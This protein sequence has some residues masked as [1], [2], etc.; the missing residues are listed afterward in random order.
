MRIFATVLTLAV[1]FYSAANGVTL[2][3]IATFNGMGAPK[4][5]EVSP[6]GTWVTVMNLEGMDVTII[7]PKTLSIIKVVNFAPYKTSAQGHNYA[8]HQPIS[9]FAEKPVEC[10][11][12]PDGQYAWVSFHNGACVVRIDKNELDPPDGVDVQKAK[13][14]DKV[15][16]KSYVKT[17]AK[18]KVLSTPKVVQVTPDGKYVLVANW[19]GQSISVIDTASMKKIKDIKTGDNVIPRGI[20][21]T[22]DS[23]TAYVANMKGGSIAIIDLVKLEK[24]KN[25]YITSNPR[26]IVLSPDN[27]FLYITDNSGGKVIKYDLE[28]GKTVKSQH[29]G[30]QARTVAITP[31][32]KYLIAAAHGS[33]ELVVLSSDDLKILTKVGFVKPMGISVSPDG[34]Q[35]WVSSYGGGYVSAYEF[36]E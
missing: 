18:V 30:S 6:D 29:V 28:A 15:N 20:A 8:T 9:S 12:S 13:I 36:Q 35:V 21:I 14:E 27:K 16:K 5:V 2:K 11:F 32:G 1:A 24:V 22:S 23:K 3:K 10:G 31:D 25:L 19:F 7:D 33:D 4:A 34:K 17:L 26:H